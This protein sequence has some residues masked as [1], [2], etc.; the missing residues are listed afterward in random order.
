[1]PE[2]EKRETLIV[3]TLVAAFADLMEHDASAFRG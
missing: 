2:D 1:M 3:D